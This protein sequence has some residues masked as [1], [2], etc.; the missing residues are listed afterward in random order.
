MLRRFLESGPW[1]RRTAILGMLWT[2]ILMLPVSQALGETWVHIDT[3][4]S[5][6]R[7]KQGE[8]VVLELQ[9]IAIG[10]AGASRER[11]KGDLQTPLGEFRIAAIKD[12]A[13]YR[14]FFII[15]YPN[16]ER[17]QAALER[18]EIDEQ[19]FESI[20]R[21]SYNGSLPPQ[22]TPLG[23]NL[24]IHGLGRADPQ[25]HQMLNWTQGCVAVTN[26]EIDVLAEWIRLG[27]RV[28]ID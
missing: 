7:V 12:P 18:G 24:G 23:G 8:Q 16:M 3:K 9:D 15:D 5:I 20:R 25:M 11:T 28:V 6:L 14:R 22:D 26:E 13:Q 2:C 17:A 1:H 19:T 4:A 10:R 27:T 21:A